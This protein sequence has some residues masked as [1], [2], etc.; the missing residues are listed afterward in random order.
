M[1]RTR[2]TSR[3]DWKEHRGVRRCQG[4]G[5]EVVLGIQ[6]VVGG[7]A[8]RVFEGVLVLWG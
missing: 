5:I 8:G 6:K 3:G 4:C 2:T 1:A 7:K